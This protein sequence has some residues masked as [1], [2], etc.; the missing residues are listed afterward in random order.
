[1]TQKFGLVASL[2]RPGGNVT[3][4]NL[5]TSEMTGKRLRR[6]REL[7][8]VAM[9]VAVL[10]NPNSPEAGPQLRDVQTAAHAVG[11]PIRILNASTEDDVET[12]FATVAQ[13]HDSALLITNDADQAACRPRSPL[14]DSRSL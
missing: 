7:V 2:N 10:I 6:A 9:E 11:Q 8:P 4:L 13:R 14:F 1:M 12:T 3:G 5:L